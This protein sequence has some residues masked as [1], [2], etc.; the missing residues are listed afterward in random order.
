MKIQ[1][2]FVIDNLTELKPATLKLVNFKKIIFD[3]VPKPFEYAVIL[4]KLKN[5]QEI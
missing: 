1:N 3:G 4:E 5:S 2:S